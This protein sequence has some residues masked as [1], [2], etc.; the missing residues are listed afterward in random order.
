MAPPGPLAEPSRVDTSP[1]T[2]KVPGCLEHETGSVPEAVSLLPVP[3]S[4]VASV[5]RTVTCAD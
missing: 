5:V 2:G 4:S 1:L 3:E